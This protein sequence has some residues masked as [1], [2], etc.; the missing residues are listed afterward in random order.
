MDTSNGFG[1]RLLS[2]PSDGPVSIPRI[3]PKKTGF[4]WTSNRWEVSLRGRPGSMGMETPFRKDRCSGWIQEE[5][6]MATPTDDVADGVDMAMEDEIV[7]QIVERAFLPHSP[8]RVPTVQDVPDTQE[9]SSD[10]EVDHG[11]VESAPE[12][13]DQVAETQCVQLCDGVDEVLRQLKSQDGYVRKI[14]LE[15]GMDGRPAAQAGSTVQE[16][17]E[18]TIDLLE[19]LSR[20]L[21]CRDEAESRAQDRKEEEKKKVKKVWWRMVKFTLLSA[22]GAAIMS[23]LENNNKK[24]NRLRRKREN[25]RRAQMIKNNQMIMARSKDL[26]VDQYPR[27]SEER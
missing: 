22:G 27:I 1:H 7:K 17:V 16:R 5:T 4:D 9:P 15:A 12:R 25:A 2:L 11:P 24:K 18:E 26:K 21:R 19:V 20:V 8:A 13:V 6:R 10:V 23:L 3:D 14:C